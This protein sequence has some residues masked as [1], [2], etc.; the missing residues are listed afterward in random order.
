MRAVDLVR[1][2]REAVDL[3]PGGE[4]L[5]HYWTRSPEGLAKWVD[6]PH[7]WT[8]LRNHIVKYVGP[9]RADRIASEWFHIVF[10]IWPGE[11]KGSNPV[12]PG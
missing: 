10:K 6:K 3:N 5:K 2:A 1:V 4:Q 7:P 8:A 11:R 12:G 9:E